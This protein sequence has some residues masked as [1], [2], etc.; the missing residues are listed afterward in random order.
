[1]AYTVD[2]VWRRGKIE[3]P[4]VPSLLMQE[5][6]QDEFAYAHDYRLWSFSRIEGT[7]L[8]AAA[9][10]GTATV[11]FGSTT[12]T[13]NG[14]L[15]LDATDVGR[16]FRAGTQLPFGIVG[17][18]VSTPSI[19]L[20]SAY[21]GPTGL[22]DCTVLDAWLTMPADFQE[23]IV[24]ADPDDDFDLWFWCSEAQLNRLDPGRTSTGQP[25]VLASR[26][27]WPAVT[28][29]VGEV[30]ISTPGQ[31]R[32]ELWPHTTAARGYQMLYKK[33]PPRLQLAD[34]LPEPIG[35]RIDWIVELLLARACRWPGTEQRRNPL[36]SLPNA[37]DHQKRGEILLA[38][39]E[40]EDEDRY[41]TWYMTRTPRY[42]YP[43]D[44]RFM[45][46]HD[47]GWFGGTFR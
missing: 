8:T 31:L 32:Y 44:S 47:W 24:V 9:K 37:Q 29:G 17:F 39:V 30:V 34:S 46:S 13:L 1:M 26:S 3:A 7:L 12:V 25:Y 40:L 45:Q 6:V 15:V 41:P 19:R 28:A 35:T 18:T 43:L 38:R 11:T 27:P 22:V 20:E 36:Y 42:G 21:T 4:L 33:R 2:Q 16:Q 5:W 23:F 10:T 14:T